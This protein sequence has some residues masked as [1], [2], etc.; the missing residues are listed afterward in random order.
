MHF[1][2]PFSPCR[3]FE[4]RTFVSWRPMPP[5][6]LCRRDCCLA[7]RHGQCLS[8]GGSACP[9]YVTPPWMPLDGWAQ[10]SFESNAMGGR[11]RTENRARCDFRDAASPPYGCAPPGVW[12]SQRQCRDDAVQGFLCRLFAE[13]LAADGL[14][15]CPE[16]YHETSPAI[17]SGSPGD[18]DLCAS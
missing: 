9:S 13:L 6:T 16:S 10:D 12:A 15:Q 5:E 17:L 2:I 7:L 1:Y 14:L 11:V 8:A 4:A 3:H 18:A